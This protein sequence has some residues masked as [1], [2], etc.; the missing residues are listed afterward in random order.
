MP[1]LHTTLNHACGHT[2]EYETPEGWQ[3]LTDAE[4]SAR[5]CGSCEVGER[6][7]PF[8]DDQ[9]K[10]QTL[11]ELKAAYDSGELSREDWL[12]IDNDCTP[13]YRDR[14]GEFEKVFDGENPECLLAEALKLL[15]IPF[16]YA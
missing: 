4:L 16:N 13:V 11:A 8:Q 2:V 14:E 3:T 10:Y 5:P 9:M 7:D 12:T 15:G 6:D 1:D